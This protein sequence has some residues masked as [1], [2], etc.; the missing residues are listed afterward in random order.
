MEYR[1]VSKKPLYRGFFSM[2]AIEVEH[3]RFDGG[4]QT[5]L[6]ENMER[7]DA[8]AMLLFDPQT[9][10]V[11]LLEQFRIG[12]VPR[13]DNPW[14][15]EI[16]A[17]IVDEG[18]TVEQAIVR[19]AHE[20]AG[21]VPYRTTWLGRYYTTPGACSERIDLFL[22]LVDS[23]TPAGDGG[24]MAD[25]HED[26]RSYW[27]SRAEAMQM[28]TDGRIASGAPML[29]LLLAFGCQGVVNNK[30]FTTEDTKDAE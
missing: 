11:L 2:D 27:V 29:A 1:I 19:E 5:V 26:I 6:R 28:L 7:G 23:S 16:V 15:I 12:P 13:Q 9:D 20:E 17:G 30:S 25:E 24:G 14:L 10:Q 18:E 3:D 8:A 22:G 4:K 21:F